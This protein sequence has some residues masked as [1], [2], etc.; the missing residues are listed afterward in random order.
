MPSR[1]KHVLKLL[2]CY[3]DTG[4]KGKQSHTE[5]SLMEYRYTE[6]FITAHSDSNATH[7]SAKPTAT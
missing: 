3:M 5:C 4:P 2:H 7:Q 1:A 6:L